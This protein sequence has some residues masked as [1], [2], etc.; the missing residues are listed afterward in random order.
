MSL[1]DRVRFL[2]IVQ[3]KLNV[4]S[5]D[6]VLEVCVEKIKKMEMKSGVFT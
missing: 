4:A 5:S 2:K 3:N 6:C 1:E